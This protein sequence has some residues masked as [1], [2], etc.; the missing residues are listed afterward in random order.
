MSD[1]DDDEESLL[2]RVRVVKNYEKMTVVKVESKYDGDTDAQLNHLFGTFK[3]G[4]YKGKM[5]IEM[6]H[7]DELNDL[8]G[9]YVQGLQW[10][11]H[12]YYFG[13]Q[14]WGWFYPYHY[15][16]M[17]S[18]LVP[19]LQGAVDSV[20]AWTMGKPFKPFE[21]LMGVLPASSIKLLPRA[22][23]DLV[24]SSES[25]IKDFYPVD[26]ELDLNGKKNDWEAVVKI[27]FVQEDRLIVAMSSKNHLLTAEEVR[28]N[29]TG[30][31]HAYKYVQSK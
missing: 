22:Y 30:E 26:F 18:D 8:R 10:V 3:H 20:P 28:R 19:D 5:G 29:S 25:P 27:P 4:Y 12:Y 31:S 1:E 13:V 11:M 15:A 24:L 23:H 16:P 21:Q 2:A 9:H 6:S 14:S 17:I 7:A